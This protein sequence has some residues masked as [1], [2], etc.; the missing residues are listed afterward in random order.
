MALEE[1]DVSGRPGIP[2]VPW[3]VPVTVS[4]VFART[5]WGGECDSSRRDLWGLLRQEE[6]RGKREEEG[7]KGK[8]MK[9]I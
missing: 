7:G 1:V 4:R 8:E 2:K 5:V 6:G 3:T 9:E